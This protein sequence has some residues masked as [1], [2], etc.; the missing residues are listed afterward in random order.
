M[1]VATSIPSATLKTLNFDIALVVLATKRRPVLF[2]I[3]VFI[4]SIDIRT[5]P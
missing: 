5:D 3:E 4:F 1:A 2:C